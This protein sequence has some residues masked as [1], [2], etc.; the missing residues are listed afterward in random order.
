MAKKAVAKKQV[1]Q[2]TKVGLNKS[3]SV[4]PSSFK[5]GGMKKKMK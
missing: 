3:A 1:P 2:G 5:K 4:S